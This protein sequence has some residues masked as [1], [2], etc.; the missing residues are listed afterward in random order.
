[1]M[2]WTISDVIGTLGVGCVVLA[3]FQIQS[4]RWQAQQLIFPL[5]NL[6]G[7]L[8]I[9]VSLYATPNIPSIIIECV[10]ITISLYGMYRIY[11]NG[12]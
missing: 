9:L 4:G 8:C 3:Y 2:H 11:K 10:W 6:V 7:A 5:T 12:Q 1:M